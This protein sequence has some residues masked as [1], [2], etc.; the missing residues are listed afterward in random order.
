LGKGDKRLPV[1]PAALQGCR[2]VLWIIG[3]KAKMV[4]SDDLSQVDFRTT[5]RVKA[6]RFQFSRS[7]CPIYRKTDRGRRTDRYRL[8]PPDGQ[9]DD[10]Q[11]W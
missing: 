10:H 5:A 1:I 2:E 8:G 3:V 11:A 7:A 6:P 4:V 9:P